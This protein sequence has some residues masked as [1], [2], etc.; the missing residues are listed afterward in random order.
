MKEKFPTFNKDYE[1]KKS[2]K[3]EK[4]QENS[5]SKVAEQAV[6]KRALKDEPKEDQQEVNTLDLVSLLLL[7]GNLSDSFCMASVYR[8]IIFNCRAEVDWIISHQELMVHVR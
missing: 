8:H 1:Q 4:I 6:K 7:F 5:K 2:E 3:M